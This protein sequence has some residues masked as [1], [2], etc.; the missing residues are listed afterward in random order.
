MDVK[1]TLPESFTLDHD[2]VRAPFVRL[3][4]H[5]T[6]TGGGEI[7]KWDLRFAQPNEAHLSMPVIHSIEHSLATTLRTI[8][9]AVIDISPMGCQTGFYVSVDAAEL[10][11]F[12]VFTD[13]LARG[14]ETA[15]EL[16]TVPG[17]TRTECGWAESHTLEGAHEALRAFLDAR[18]T[19][20]DVFAG[21]GA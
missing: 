5:T 19:W 6:L 16:S 11:E 9:D 14:I 8:T 2:A 15:L 4:G 1:L 3:A 7:V 17:S 21:T 20:A 18:D 12:D 10:G 13:V